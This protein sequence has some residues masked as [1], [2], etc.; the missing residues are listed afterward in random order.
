[1]DGGDGLEEI[2]DHA[3][4]SGV[5]GVGESIVFLDLA[6]P[7]VELHVDA[8]DGDEADAAVIHVEAGLRVFFPGD[9]S[10]FDAV[11]E[12]ERG[13]LFLTGTLEPLF[14]IVGAGAE[15]RGHESMGI[16]GGG[17][18][19]SIELLEGFGGFEVF[20]FKLQLL[21]GGEHD[22][23]AKLAAAFHPPI[24]HPPETRSPGGVDIASD[25]F[26]LFLSRWSCKHKSALRKCAKAFWQGEFCICHI[27]FQFLQ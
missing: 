9:F 23:V 6:E 16:A 17:G 8:F 13:E 2:A 27:I 26:P 24:G 15:L 25:L 20:E 22:G 5:P 12:F 14:G 19:R 10:G 4:A 21:F 7:E 1:V 18:V 3:E 11:L